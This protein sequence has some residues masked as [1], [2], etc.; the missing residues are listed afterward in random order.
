LRGEAGV[1]VVAVGR[2]GGGALRGAPGGTWR[3]VLGGRE[4]S[5][6]AAVPVERTVGG[7]GVAVYERL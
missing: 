7:Y 3:E 2:G 1:V 5:F 4:L 6:D